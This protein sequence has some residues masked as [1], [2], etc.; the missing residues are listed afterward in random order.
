[1]LLEIQVSAKHSLK[2][3]PGRDHPAQLP[4][5][6]AHGCRGDA[7]HALELTGDD[8]NTDNGKSDAAGVRLRVSK[9]TAGERLRATGQA[10]GKSL[11]RRVTWRSGDVMMW[12]RRHDR[13]PRPR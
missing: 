3:T 1:L 2:V 7:C 12:P 9:N 6:C 4:S 10:A 13:W 5:R 8:Q 11:R